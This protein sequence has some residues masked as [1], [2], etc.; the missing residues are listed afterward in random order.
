MTLRNT[1]PKLAAYYI[2][3]LLL[4][5]LP[6]SSCSS[7]AGDN[8][9]LYQAIQKNDVAAV[10]KLLDQGANPN[11]TIIRPGSQWHNEVIRTTTSEW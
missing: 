8:S 3:I 1:R 5:L 10:R 7:P 11:S 9:A 4:S 2:L 6:G